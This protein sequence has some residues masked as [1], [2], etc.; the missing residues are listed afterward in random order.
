M[1]EV[2]PAPL[3][4]LPAMGT[5]SMLPL[6]DRLGRLAGMD[7]RYWQLVAQAAVPPGG[8]VLDVGCGTGAVTLR[9]ALAVPDATVTGVD[10]DGAAVA[11]ARRKAGEQGVRARFEQAYAQ[12]LPAGDGSVDRVLSSLM[13]HHLPAGTKAAMVSEVRRV[14]APGGSLHLMDIDGDR[15]EWSGLL[16]PVRAAMTLTHRAAALAQGRRGGQ[17]GA[18][19]HG[20]GHGGH[21]V[22][23]H[24]DGEPGLAHASSTEV[25]DLLAAAGLP[26][27]EVGRAVSRM[28]GLTYYRATPAG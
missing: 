7:E 27:V 19:G 14:L 1:T 16:R 10:P 8:T 2:R 5:P 24:D 12:H 6:Y 25:L 21:A 9:V 11:L 15:P 26:G 20:H 4:Y 3:D 18:H 28:G 22:Q 13:F 23:G 17:G